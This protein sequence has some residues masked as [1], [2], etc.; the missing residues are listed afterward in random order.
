[1]PSS[2]TAACGG[3]GYQVT[4]SVVLK[5]TR[6]VAGRVVLRQGMELFRHINRKV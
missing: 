2:G 6:K 4:L 1:M 5:K 3:R